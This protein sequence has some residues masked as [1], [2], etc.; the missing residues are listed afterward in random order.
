MSPSLAAS[1]S[2][3]N[4]RMADEIARLRRTSVNIPD[5]LSFTTERLV[6]EFGVEFLSALAA[7]LREAEIK[8]GY[9]DHWARA[10]WEQECRAEL[11]RHIEKG[12][13]RD[14]AAYCAFMWKRGWST[15]A[16]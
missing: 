10:D 7:K 1:L 9:S 12:D 16:P 11:M 13:P 15:A 2:E 4:D 3:S 8:H 6:L 5:G 14:V